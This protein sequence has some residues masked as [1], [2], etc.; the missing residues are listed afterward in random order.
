MMSDAVKTGKTVKLKS[1]MA[2][3]YGISMATLRKWL[4]DLGIQNK[5]QILTIK[6]ISQL[7]EEY[8]EPDYDLITP[9]PIGKA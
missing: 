5:G 9:K 1:E 6:Q 2:R 7:E 3:A 8:G 4:S